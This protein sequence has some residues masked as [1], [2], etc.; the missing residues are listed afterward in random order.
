MAESLQPLGDPGWYVADLVSTLVVGDGWT[1]LLERWWVVAEQPLDELLV[2]L[3]V[4]R[5]RDRPWAV[6]PVTHVHLP[7][8]DAAVDAHGAEV[9]GDL[10]PAS[11][12]GR[13]IVVVRLPRPLEPC[14]THTFDLTLLVP[15]PA[16]SDRH[17]VMPAVP[18]HRLEVRVHF[19]G[20]DVPTEV[21]RVA[22][23]DA[24]GAGDAGD[25]GG[26]VRVD[27]AGDVAVVFTRLRAGLTYGVAW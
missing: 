22:G 6:R 24:G 2:E 18:C 23:D 20:P 16:V 13:Q 26:T 5:P 25:A 19:A 27:R 10:W 11:A 21:R 14:E 7:L 17:V 4:D 15:A 12:S 1:R 9:T 8:S 3:D